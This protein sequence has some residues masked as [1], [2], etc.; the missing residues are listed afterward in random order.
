MR[1]DNEIEV[2]WKEDGYKLPLPLGPMAQGAD[3]Q[4]VSRLA[5]AGPP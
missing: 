2:L 1:L 4:R 3:V 5:C